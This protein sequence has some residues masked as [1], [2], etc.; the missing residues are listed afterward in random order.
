[1]GRYWNMDEI[2]GSARND[3]SGNIWD[4]GEWS[5]QEA[6]GSGYRPIYQSPG[7]I[8]YAADFGDESGGEGL[9]SFAPNSLLD[10]DFT[11]SCWVNYNTSSGF[12]GQGLISVTK[13][14][15]G[16]VKLIRT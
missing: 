13:G 11:F 6:T 7:I 2:D 12:D 14:K 16:A 15:S 3:S 4:L 5:F 10:G 8:N 1:M 9:V